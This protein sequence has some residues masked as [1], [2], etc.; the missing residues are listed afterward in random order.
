MEKEIVLQKKQTE[1]LD[2]VPVS[3]TREEI[4]IQITTAKAYPRDIDQ[5]MDDSLSMAT[6]ND[7][8]A[9]KCFYS[10]TKG[11]KSIE[12]P[13]VRL[14]EIVAVNYGNLRFGQKFVGFTEDGNSVIAEGFAYDLQ[15]NVAARIETTRRIVDK[16][17][18]R[19][20]IDV[21]ETTKLAAGAIAKRQ[22]IFQIIP[23]SFIQEIFEKCKK[24]AV[25]DIKSLTARRTKAIEHFTKFGVTID[26]ILATLGKPSIEEVGLKDLELLLGLSTAIK[27]GDTDIDTAFP[28]IMKEAPKS[29]TEKVAAKAAEVKPVVVDPIEAAIDSQAESRTPGE[30]G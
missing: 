29:L 11:G 9:A 13:S 26:R 27:D 16:Y 21:I 1:V 23:M 30:E 25:G 6:R 22:A 19:Y 15:K 28:P 24:V 14:S 5:F 8:V 18:K 2:L 4:D 3:A 7:D 17:G 12:G 10:L 20:G